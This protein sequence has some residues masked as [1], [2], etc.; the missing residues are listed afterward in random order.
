V[1]DK[2]PVRGVIYDRNMQVMAANQTL[3]KIYVSPNYVSD[4]ASAAASLAKVL[5]DSE[6]RILT[7]ISGPNTALI[8]QSPISTEM[9]QQI[10]TLDIFGVNFEAVPKRIYPHGEL[11]SQVVGF[12]GWDGRERRG[13]TGVEGNYNGDLAGQKLITELSNIPFDANANSSPPPGRSVVLTI[14]RTLQYIAEEELLDA[15]NTYGAVSGSVLVMDPRT[16]EILAMAGYPTFDANAYAEAKPEYLK[17]PV[18]SDAY[19]PGSVFKIVTAALALRS[20]KITPD[21]TYL[22]KRVFQIGGVSIYNWDR[23]GH[24]S[25]NFSQILIYSWNVG[26]STLSVEV[27]GQEAFYKGLKDFGVGD[28]TGIDLEGEA[29]GFLKEPGISLYWSDSDLATNS[30]GQGLT[31][32]PL[33]MLSFANV[34]AN[35]GLMMQPHVRLATIDGDRLIKS[36]PVPVRSPITPDVAAQIR[37][38]LVQAVNIGEARAGRIPGIQIAGKTGTA[39]FVDSAT[40]QYD[41]TLQMATYVGFFPADEPRVSILIK[42][43]KVSTFASESAAPAWSKLAQRIAVAMN[44]PTDAQRAELRAAGGQTDQISFR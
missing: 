44:I 30:F 6:S 23:A 20:G 19:E 16:G 2:A 7:L 18:V 40:G 25:Q 3:W 37:D 26:T 22:D 17:N 12:V 11:A 9:A 24:G 8:T 4:K 39:Q 29:P 14:D 42:L 10:E 35:G 31:V 1:D 33:Q 21:W 43:D 27:L 36:E 41:P 32:T 13:Y 5:G 15:V 28:P 34:I 38:I